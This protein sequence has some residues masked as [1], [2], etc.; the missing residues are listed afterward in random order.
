MDR[1]MDYVLEL[2][3]DWAMYATLLFMAF[4]VTYTYVLPIIGE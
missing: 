3:P 1:F 4:F 2:M